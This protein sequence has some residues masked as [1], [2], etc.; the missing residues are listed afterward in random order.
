MHYSL[1]LATPYPSP[2]CSSLDHSAVKV[3]SIKILAVKLK[4]ISGR[5][6]YC[7][8]QKQI[9]ELENQPNLSDYEL[10]KLRNLKEQNELFSSLGIDSL[11]D[12]IDNDI[13]Q[14]RVKTGII[15][16]SSQTLQPPSRRSSRIAQMD[17][18]SYFEGK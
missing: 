12:D 14:H 3:K 13:T 16:I 17:K 5:K 10:C 9:Y 15:S 4:Y 18:A 7:P 11:K 1:F 6:S 2:L 8:L